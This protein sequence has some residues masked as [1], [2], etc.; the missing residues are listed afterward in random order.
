MD[1]TKLFEAILEMSIQLQTVID[2]LVEHGIISAEE[3]NKKTE[4]YNKSEDIID[5]L[6]ELEAMEKI[7]DIFSKKDFSNE[8]REFIKQYQETHNIPED[9]KLDDEAMD[10]LGLSLGTLIYDKEKGWNI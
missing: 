4:S 2:L 1:E 10:F 9:Y 8:N 3:F 6:N 7:K 5:A